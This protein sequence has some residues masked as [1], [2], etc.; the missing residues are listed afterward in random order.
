MPGGGSVPTRAPALTGRAAIFSR[1]RVQKMSGGMLSY[2]VPLD[3]ERAR[4]A[5]ARVFVT[6]TEQAVLQ[7]A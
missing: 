1:R 4:A 2:S 5:V 3:S 7:A 6:L